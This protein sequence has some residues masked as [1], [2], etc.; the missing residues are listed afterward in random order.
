[1][2][3]Q[4]SKN[5]LAQLPTVPPHLDFTPKEYQELVEYKAAGCPGIARVKDS[6]VFKWLNLY[7]AGKSYEEIAK[8]TKG[9]LP[10]IL[11]TS[12]KHNWAKKRFD[13]LS[14]VQDKLA[15]RLQANRL[16]ALVFLTDVQSYVHSTIGKHI[17]EFLETQNPELEKKI[18]LKSLDKYYKAVDMIEKLAFNKKDG[19]QAP[20]AVFNNFFGKTSITKTGPNSVQ[21]EVSEPDSD[22]SILELEAQKVRMEEEE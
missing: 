17:R 12:E 4:D 8:Q 9:S 1:M 21:V 14:A 22:M 5:P 3:N 6:D 16:E 18:D 2:E 20:Q 11:L 15:N 10:Q 19:E 13:Y 7:Y